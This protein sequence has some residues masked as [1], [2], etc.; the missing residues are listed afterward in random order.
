M[1]K[2]G[3]SILVYAL[4]QIGVRKTFGIPG[5]H[6]TEIYNQLNNSRNIEPIIVTHE[7]SAG[8]MADAVSRTSDSIGTIVIV[9]GAGLTHAMSAIGETLVDGIPLLIISGGINKESGKSFQMHQLNMERVVDGIVKGYFMINEL[10][11]I[12]PTIYEAYGL[13]ISGEP[14]P[15]FVEMPVRTQLISDSVELPPY[16][17]K[18]KHN[19]FIISKESSGEMSLFA[20]N[21]SVTDKLSKAVSLLSEANFPALYVGWGAVDATEEIKILVELLAAPVATTIQGISAFPFNHP[22]HAGIGFGPS[23]A[24][25]AQ[26][27]FKNCDCLLA[28]GLK[29]SELAT[30][31]YQMD[32]PENLIHIDIN[33]DVFH[34]NYHAKVALEGDAKIVLNEL[35]SGLKHSNPKTKNN[36]ANLSESI[37]LDKEAYR[38]S[39]FANPGEQM[40]TPGFFYNALRN[41]LPE[42]AIMVADD[43]THML[44]TA[45][46]FPVLHAR[47]FICPTDYSGMGYG[48]PAAIGAKLIN[49]HNMVTAIIGD[50]ALLMCGNELITSHI[51]KLGILIFVFRDNES[52]KLTQK[53]G[54]ENTKLALSAIGAINIK[55][56]ADA[57][58]AEYMA[59][60]TDIDISGVLTKADEKLKSG[61]TV[62]VE[63]NIDYS[64]KPSFTSNLLKPKSNRISFTQKLKLMFKGSGTN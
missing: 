24:P 30:G 13:A 45:E 32:V 44:M 7:L 35:I 52:Q 22:L 28:V 31:N 40:V 61:K 25:A 34:K 33:P 46:L 57:V 8:Y 42:D 50:G 12:V 23:A 63:V 11:Q 15:V 20:D 36:I 18:P 19:P 29:F 6:N 41:Y 21:E 48:I 43:G 47:H 4:E 27:S 55:G 16:I 9:P 2:N 64:R 26:N 49:R 5:M 14:G 3:A 37:K 59:L 58:H 51:N 62:I 60:K 38:N 1:K 53:Q 10:D 17:K 39:W 56:F 54:D